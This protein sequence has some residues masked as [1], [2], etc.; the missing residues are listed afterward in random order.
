MSKFI[1]LIGQKFGSL[2]VL[3]RADSKSKQTAWEVKC[4]CGN[5]IVVLGVNLKRN[6]TTSCGCKREPNLVGKTFG[7]L[8]V[9]ERAENYFTQNGKSE[10]QWLCECQCGNKTVVLGHNLLKGQTQ[11]CGCLAR[12]H[13]AIRATRHGESDS[14]LYHIWTGMKQR[15]YNPKAK[16]Y[17][18]YGGR[19]ITVCDEWKDNFQAFYDWAMANGYD[20]ML[21]I[22]RINSNDIYN[23]LNCRWATMEE[24]QNNK[25]NNHLLTY[26]GE[27]LTVNQ[28]A[29]K[30][31]LNIGVFKF[32]ISK[33][34]DVETAIKITSKAKNVG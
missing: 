11:S 2:T 4:D 30:Y 25:R 13:S 26:K 29:R 31:G 12:E 32:N 22:D 23:P 3:K 18:D 24:Q 17:K 15:C 1:D 9:I 5:T 6:N 7:R 28:M 14:R 8:I 20:D 19:G 34:I 16:S 27:T 21:S 33:G 10:R